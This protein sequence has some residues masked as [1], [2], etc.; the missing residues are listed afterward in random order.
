MSHFLRALGLWLQ[1]FSRD[2]IA[3]RNASIYI[4]SAL[5][6]FEYSHEAAPPWYAV[7]HLAQKGS[8]IGPHLRAFK[9]IP[10]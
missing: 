1:M 9:I 4:W 3:A 5:Q 7:A 6:P 10:R 8:P 2:P